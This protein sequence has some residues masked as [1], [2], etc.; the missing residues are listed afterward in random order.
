MSTGHTPSTV[1]D[2]NDPGDDTLER[3]KYQ[4]S[5]AAINCVRLVSSKP[6]I[7]R[8]I[9]ENYEDI[10]LELADGSFIGQ[11]VKTRNLDLDP[12]K[13]TDNAVTKSLCRFC[14]LDQAFPGAFSTFDFSTNHWFW[15]ASENERNLPWL[16]KRIKERGGVKRLPSKNPLR[17]FVQ[18]LC[19]Q[20]DLA[21]SSVVSTLCRT[22]LNCRKESV[23]SIASHVREAVGTYPETSNLT[24]SQNAKIAEDL[25]N[26]TFQASSKKMDGNVADL[27]A[28]GTDFKDVLNAH[29]LAGKCITHKQVK[30]VLVPP[31]PSTE[32]LELAALVPIESLPVHLAVMVQKLDKGGLQAARIEQMNDLVYSFHALILRWLSRYGREQAEE[33]YQTLLATV[34]FECTESQVAC[35]AADKPYAPE[36]YEQL[37]TRLQSR[38]ADEHDSLH[39]CRAEHLM[40]AAGM[41]TEQCH[42]WWSPKFEIERVEP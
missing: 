20:T 35:E 17:S 31:N 27:Y 38:V 18:R 3:Y 39:G 6:E 26:L 1:L 23:G 9:C 10:I 29:V 4:C 16:I 22:V 40:G 11:Q 32:P 25:V 42:A 34:K 5:V 14:S 15:E 30:E 37:F 41:L 2:L 7:V 8:V 36:M 19:A 33:R 28:A 24:L 12:F 21:E 13:A